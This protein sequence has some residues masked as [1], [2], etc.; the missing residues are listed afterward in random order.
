MPDISMC[1]NVQCVKRLTCYRYIAKPS[2]YQSYMDFDALD[3]RSYMGV[4]KPYDFD[5]NRLCP[6]CKDKIDIGVLCDKCLKELNEI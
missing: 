2:E 1:V 6:Q 4:Y 5:G 3:C